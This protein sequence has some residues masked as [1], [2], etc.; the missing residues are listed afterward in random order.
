[1]SALHISPYMDKL[2]GFPVTHL[3]IKRETV[4]RQGVQ[5]QNSFFRRRKFLIVVTDNA[6]R[7]GVG[8]R[9]DRPFLV[10]AIVTEKRAAIFFVIFR[11]Y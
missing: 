2:V 10:R 8:S 9:S 5:I 4:W 7:R 6:I 11:S 1:M 3:E